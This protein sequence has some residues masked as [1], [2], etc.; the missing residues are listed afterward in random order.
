M[1]SYIVTLATLALLALLALP[2][3][4]Q[5]EDTR[6]VV[7]DLLRIRLDCGSPESI[8]VGNGGDEPVIL[9]GISSSQDRRGDP[10]ITF[11]IEIAPGLAEMVRLGASDG[12]GEIFEDGAQEWATVYGSER[13]YRAPCGPDDKV[14]ADFAPPGRQDM[15]APGS[16]IGQ[17]AENKQGG[18]GQVPSRLPATGAGGMVGSAPSI[19][20][21]AGALSLVAG[22]G[23]FLVRRRAQRRPCRRCAR[24][25]A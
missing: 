18:T 21:V 24:R 17:G 2:T 19:G 11:N 9:Q 10:E 22:Y 3:S 4:A 23:Y 16:D 25:T 13:E 5:E 20:Q 1:K 6:E 14:L 15:P 12:S 7:D 8:T